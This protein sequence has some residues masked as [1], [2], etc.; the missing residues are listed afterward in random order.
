MA[1]LLTVEFSFAQQATPAP[2]QSRENYLNKSQNQ[3]IG[4]WF[5]M[6]GGVALLVRTAGNHA[7]NSISNVPP[8]FPIVPVA[9]SAG[10]IGGSIALFKA[11]SRNKKKTLGAAAYFN[12]LS[13][14][15]TQSATSG[16][17]FVPAFSIKLN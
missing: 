15:S 5:L 14:P 11:S 17:T 8:P 13:I 1:L 4:A 3:K 7:V 6:L 10:C 9:L 12:I 2:T 16:T